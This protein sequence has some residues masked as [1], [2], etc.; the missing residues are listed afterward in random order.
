MRF[1]AESNRCFGNQKPLLVAAL[2]F[3]KVSLVALSLKFK[4]LNKSLVIIVCDHDRCASGR[5]KTIR[6]MPTRRITCTSRTRLILAVP[7]I[8]LSTV[9]GAQTCAI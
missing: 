7:G 6:L 3:T 4:L 8:R 1:P 2:N 5:V 9:K